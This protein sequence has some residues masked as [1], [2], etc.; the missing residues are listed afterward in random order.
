MRK[1]SSVCV[2]HTLFTIGND[3]VIHSCLFKIISRVGVNA[4]ML[5]Q[6]LHFADL[7]LFDSTR[8]GCVALA[9]FGLA[10]MVSCSK[11]AEEPLYGPKLL[12]GKGSCV[13][14]QFTSI[15][16]LLSDMCQ[17]QVSTVRDQFEWSKFRGCLSFGVSIRTQRAS[18]NYLGGPGA[19]GATVWRQS[20]KSS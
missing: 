4:S 3:V 10:S 9:S 15:Y 13:L 14:E 19:D 17:C 11:S 20:R 18:V 8:Q 12:H 2:I 6:R 1:A 16:G 5:Q 7:A